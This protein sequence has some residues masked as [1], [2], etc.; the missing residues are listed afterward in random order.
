MF[1]LGSCFKVNAER[2]LSITYC[3]FAV[4]LSL[5]TAMQLRNWSWLIAGI[6]LGVTYSLPTGSLDGRPED[7]RRFSTRSQGGNKKSRVSIASAVNT[8]SC[9]FHILTYDRAQQ[10]NQRDYIDLPFPIWIR[11]W[12]IVSPDTWDMILKM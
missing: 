5:G 11:N 4:F 8:A 3:A 2:L 7:A 1:Y 9:P 10:I 6:S 12:N